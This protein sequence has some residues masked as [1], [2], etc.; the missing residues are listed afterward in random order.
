MYCI[1]I[2]I[3]LFLI[4]LSPVGLTSGFAFWVWTPE[5]NKWVNPKYAVKDTPSEQLEYA[6]GFYQAKEYKEAIPEFRK[7]IR[8]YPR[9]REAADAQYYIGASWEA[10]DNPDEAFKSYQEVIEK[11]PFSER[12][13]EIVRK[14]YDISVKLFEGKGN[15]GGWAKTFT[16]GDYAVVDMFKTVI[17]NAPYGELAAPSRYKI[18]LYLMENIMYQEARDEFEKVIND[19]P[20]SEWAK[21]AKYQIA[22]CD[23][24]RST[25]AQY[26]QKITQEAVKEFNDFVK[27]YP[28]AELSDQAKEQIQKLRDK[29]AESHFHIARFYEK[30]QKYQSALVYYQTIVDDF[31][32]SQW[33]AEA[34]KKIRELS[35]KQQ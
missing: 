15:R 29:E 33:T 12:S 8:H 27:N 18:G 24:K 6:L 13:A 20:E 30:N 28:E 3:F 22:I 2:L 9:S 21:A 26:D 17:K 25:G 11:Y 19:Y 5:T 1:R 35:A 32:N 7:L 34:L 10:M 4:I 14:Q 23:T 31:K 16:G